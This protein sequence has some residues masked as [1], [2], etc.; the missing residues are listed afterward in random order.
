MIIRSFCTSIKQAFRQIFRNRAMTFASL[1]S[2]TAMLLILG[3]FFILVVNVNVVTESAKQQFD[4][5]QVYLLDETTQEQ[6][7]EIA[8][9]LKQNGNVKS[10]EYLTKEQALEEYKVKWGDKAYLL[11]G[12]PENPLPNSLRIKV[13]NLEDADKVVEKVKTF[14]GIEDVKYYQTTVDKLLSITNFIQWGALIIII[15]LV[16]I[17]VVVV[18]NTIKL[19]VLAREREISIM[20]YVGATNWFIRGPFL[21]EG[22]LIGF[23]SA[24]VSVGL[25]SLI[26][27][28]VTE[29]LGQE[30]FL[31][32]STALVD[33]K[34]LIW[35]LIWIFVA[36]G[37]CIGAFGSILS[38]RR[39]LDT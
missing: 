20:K 1:F 35:N 5:I 36:L 27:Y 11:E 16:V 12:L 2:I 37:V 25:I 10:V 7:E 19:T 3:L 22:M 17:S 24:A 34:F 14:S 6:A 8:G 33:E 28:K 18:S 30:A 39:F 23:L 31:M 26:Y 32:F 13:S 9:R 4:T 21:A 29:T 15:F 38:M